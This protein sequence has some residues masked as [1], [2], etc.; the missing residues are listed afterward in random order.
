MFRVIEHARMTIGTKS[1]ATLST[2]YLNALEY[3]KERI[4]GADMTQM[5]DK[6][7]PRV[8]IIR[9]PDVRRMLL[10]QKAYAEGL[11][12]LWMYAAYCQ[13]M[14]ALDPEG[15]WDRRSDLLLPLVK[16]Y[17]SEKAYVLLAQSLQV[18]G[19]SGYIQDY[20]IE[21]YIR[22][23]KIDTVYEG[24]TGIQAMDLF[25]RKIARD[26]GQTLAALAAEIG[27]FVKAGGDGDPLGAERGILGKMLDD[28]QGQIGAM[29]EDLMASMGGEAERIYEVGLHANSCSSRWPRWSSPG[30]SSVTPRSPIPGGQRPFYLARWSR[31][32]GSSA[33][34]LPRSPHVG[35]PPRP[36]TAG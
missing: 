3:A 32:A 12:A 9:H 27:E 10:M 16:G 23:S 36:R 28:V 11:R 14:D 19:G 26:Q 17:S 33:T 8:P 29:V 7:A 24:T 31:R 22:D 13:H 30:S 35:P 21:Q 1:A 20:P 25:F 18:L 6:T 2:G 5:T 15:G 4:Q 34:S